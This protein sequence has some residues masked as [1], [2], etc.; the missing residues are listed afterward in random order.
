MKM[1][2]D[3]P[4]WRHSTAAGADK[5]RAWEMEQSGCDLLD[6]GGSRNAME[7]GARAP[8]V[9]ASSRFL[10]R[11][12]SSCCCETFPDGELPSPS[13]PPVPSSRGHEAAAGLLRP[14]TPGV[15]VLSIAV[16]CWRD[17]SSQ[18]RRNAR[19]QSAAGL[20]FG[21]LGAAGLMEADEASRRMSRVIFQEGYT[22]ISAAIKELKQRAMGKD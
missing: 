13:H 2:Q 4:G 16:A 21:M 7:G 5:G 8:I 3:G 17:I 19:S 14:C 11:T 9:A 15:F 18:R 6:D 20:G 12:F 10:L 22:E 1:G